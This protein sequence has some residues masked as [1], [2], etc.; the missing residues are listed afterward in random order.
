MSSKHYKLGNL[1]VFVDRNRMS[2]DGKTEELMPLEPVADKWRAFGWNVV[3]VDGHI[4]EQL[5]ARSRRSSAY[6]QRCTNVIIGNTVKGRG[7]SFMENVTS[8]HA[9]RITEEQLILA[10]TELLEAF[11]KKWGVE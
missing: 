6:R 1:V 8:W 7:V 9:G 11:N 4:M 3:E 10:K 5:R 2:L